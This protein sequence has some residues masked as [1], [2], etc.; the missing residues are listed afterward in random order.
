M[1][2]HAQQIE[3]ELFGKPYS[4]KT[5]ASGGVVESLDTATTTNSHHHQF[6]HAQL[7]PSHFRSLMTQLGLAKNDY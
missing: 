5:K 2:L 7:L 4:I 1:M 3:F 6:N